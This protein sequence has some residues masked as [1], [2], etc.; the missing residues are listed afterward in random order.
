MARL[1]AEFE[2]VRV[3]CALAVKREEVHRMLVELTNEYFEERLFGW[4]D[5]SC[6][7]R[8]SECGLDQRR[9]ESVLNVPKYFDDGPILKVKGWKKRKRSS[10]AQVQAGEL[11]MTD[12]LESSG[13]YSST[14]ASTHAGVFPPRKTSLQAGTALLSAAFGPM[15]PLPPPCRNAVVA[16]HDGGLPAPSFLEPLPSR[17]SW[18]ATWEGAV[19]NVLSSCDGVTMTGFR[20]RPRL[21]RGG[22]IIIDRVPC[23]SLPCTLNASDASVT[24]PLGSPSPQTVITYGSGMARSGHDTATLGADGPSHSL[25]LGFKKGV[26]TMGPGDGGAGADDASTMPKAPP[27]HQLLDLLPKKTNTAL[28]SR[29]IEE[30]CALGLLEDYEKKG[31]VGIERVGLGAG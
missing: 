16:G 27:S 6:S 4:I 20:H 19:P 2:R 12:G 22:R 28:L 30:V 18:P 7:P 23:P 13:R 10:W 5:T 25:C 21:G 14:M 1:K 26:L 31:A 24:V 8:R 9:V 15:R 17:N 3:L 11:P 29:R